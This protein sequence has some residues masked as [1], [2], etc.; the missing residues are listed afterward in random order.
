MTQHKKGGGLQVYRF[1]DGI[2][3]TTGGRNSLRGEGR[4]LGTAKGDCLVPYD[5]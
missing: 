1:G 2:D 5:G 4:L 3:S